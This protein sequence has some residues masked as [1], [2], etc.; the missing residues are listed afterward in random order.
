M[1]VVGLKSVWSTWRVSGQIFFFTS[2]SSICLDDTIMFPEKRH[3]QRAM[4]HWLSPWTTSLPS[5]YCLTPRRGRSKAGLSP[6]VERKRPGL[7][8]WLFVLILLCDL[9]QVIPTQKNRAIQ[10]G[11]LW[12]SV[13][14]HTSHH[15]VPET[16]NPEAWQTSVS[17]QGNYDISFI[18]GESNVN[19]KILKN[20]E[21]RHYFY[22][23]EGT[24]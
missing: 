16:S 1:R 5:S 22:R 8:F 6:G 24:W 20:A 17:L 13:T 14:S 21:F 10:L 7:G 2:D 18:A 4:R 19:H 12:S 3:I 11:D 15:V 9:G 23:T